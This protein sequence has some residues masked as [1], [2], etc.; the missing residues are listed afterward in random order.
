MLLRSPPNGT[1]Q[2]CQ[3]HTLLHISRDVFLYIRSKQVKNLFLLLIELLGLINRKKVSITTY[4][5]YIV[6]IVDELLLSIQFID[7]Q[8]VNHKFSLSR[9]PEVFR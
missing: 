5:R 6:D 9:Q 8:V 4:L 2:G 1:N 3:I 7:K